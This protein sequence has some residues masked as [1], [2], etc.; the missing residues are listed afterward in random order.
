MFKLR[1][2]ER[3]DLN[4]INKWRNNSAL[5]ASLGAPYR[6]INLD[7]DIK[8]FENYM[9][10]RGNAIRCAIIFGN[11]EELIGLV[12]LVDIDF[13]NQSAEFH[14][15]I[16]DTEKQNKGVGTFAVKA[17]LYH[18]FYN[19]NLQRIELSVL[20][21][22]ERAKHLYEKC[23]FI[24]EG[25]KRKA[26]YKDGKF[27]DLLMYSALRDEIGKDHL[28]IPPIKNTIVSSYEYVSAVKYIQLKSA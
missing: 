12:S 16:G 20:D 5:I 3:K 21:T 26:K 7:V 22:N 6:F 1:E 27:V 4:I 17:M 24:C 14:I 28:L 25:R 19:M 15:M 9:A 8:W 23:G 2:L 10:N 11:T 18:A 13:I